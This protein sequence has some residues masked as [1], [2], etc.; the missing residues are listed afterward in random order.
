MQAPME[1][2]LLEFNIS[3]DIR[4]ALLHKRGK[5]AHVYMFVESIEKCNQPAVDL[6]LNH[7]GIAR[8]DYDRLIFETAKS[9]NRL[10]E[11]LEMI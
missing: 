4:S 1:K 3:E 2:I 7:Y 11:E 9:V 10:D 5:Y 8:E 6:F